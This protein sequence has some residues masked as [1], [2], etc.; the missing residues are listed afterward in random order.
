MTESLLE[1]KRLAK[2]FRVRSTTGTWRHLRA[3]D[4][5]SFS[6]RP[7][8]VV[9]IVGESGSGKST[10]GL[11][12]LRLIEPTS[13]SVRFEGSDFLAL[14]PRGLRAARGRIQAVFQ[15]PRGQLD[16]RVRIA[17]TVGEPLR[18]QG[19]TD[20]RRIRT[21]V[22]EVLELV[23]LPPE[24]AR[25]YPGQLSGGQRQRVGI[26][27][28]LAPEPKLI[29]CDEAVSALDVSVQTQVL[30]VLRRLRTDLGVSYV[31]ISHGLAA[32]RYLADTV[33][34]MYCGREVETSPA[35]DFFSGPA[36]PYSAALLSAVPS[37]D[38][39]SFRER[40][41]LRGEMPSP[42]DQPQ[43]CVFADRCF[44]AQDVCRIE[45]PPRATIGPGRT[46]ECYFPLQGGAA[47]SSL[48]AS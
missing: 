11:A 48:P 43:G 1:V 35:G 18:A 9:A 42:F 36:H 22:G 29:L 32:V 47:T 33:V 46:V 8:E 3:V 27:R 34:V 20:R 28:A 2:H 24:F 23:G 13:G 7:G 38:P 41:V 4:D 14:S 26:A 39:E 15:D 12:A 31:F 16:P 17:E 30:N 19:V 21:R 6:V 10:T 40:I 5:V 37:V 25:R 44:Q 45:R